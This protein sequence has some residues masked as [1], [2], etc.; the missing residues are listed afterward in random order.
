M[1]TKNEIRKMFERDYDLYQTLQSLAVRMPP[2]DSETKLDD[3]TDDVTL[4]EEQEKAIENAVAQYG[5]T[6]DF[7]IMVA[8]NYTQLEL[9]DAEIAQT[10]AFIAAAVDDLVGYVHSVGEG[11]S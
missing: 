7:E 11:E 2:P 10:D 6:R 3:Q 1:D 8:G 5:T 4:T 9:D